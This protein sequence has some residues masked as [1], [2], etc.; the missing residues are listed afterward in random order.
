MRRYA[1]ISVNL[2]GSSFSLGGW[3]EAEEKSQ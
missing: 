1:F 2:S 3:G